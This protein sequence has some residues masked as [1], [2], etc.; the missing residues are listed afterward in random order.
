MRVSKK[1]DGYNFTD[2]Q[3]MDLLKFLWRAILLEETGVRN[4]CYWHEL[5]QAQQVVIPKLL[6][7][8]SSCMHSPVSHIQW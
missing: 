6:Q 8:I 7:F 4:H 3:K 5:Y 2:I 1:V